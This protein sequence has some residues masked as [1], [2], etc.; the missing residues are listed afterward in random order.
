M[1]FVFMLSFASLPT[2]LKDVDLE[3]GAEFTVEVGG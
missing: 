1:V 2:E 3:S